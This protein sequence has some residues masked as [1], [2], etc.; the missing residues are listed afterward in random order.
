MW[1][2]TLNVGSKITYRTSGVHLN[3]AYQILEILNRQRPVSYFASRVGNLAFSMDGVGTKIDLLASAGLDWVSGWDAV[4]MNANDLLCVGAEPLW[5]LDYFCQGALDKKVFHG[6]L[7]GMNRALKVL[8]AELVGGE[9]AEHPGM[10]RKDSH[11][12]IAGCLIGSVPAWSRDLGQILVKEGDILLGL[13][14]SGPHANGFSLIRKILPDS[15]F[16][17]EVLAP[18]ELYHPK[19]WP[20]LENSQT[21][22]S[23]DGLV[24]I[25]GGAFLEKM[26]RAL[27]VHLAA[28]IEKGSWPV[29]P[30]FDFLRGRARLSFAQA[31]GVWNMGIGFVLICNPAGVSLI[32]R[33]LAKKRFKFWPIGEIV[34][35]VG[36]RQVMFG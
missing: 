28:K 5:F 22:K 27:P 14:S 29:P 17:K 33:A 4:A 13:A 19:V 35:C 15:K 9:T 32:S 2:Q 3:R 25:T 31:L 36:N 11:Y 30:V 12:D 10:F 20:L 8:G 21:R 34:K 16:P 18:T 7:K 23:L 26:P 1:S 6:A 24:H